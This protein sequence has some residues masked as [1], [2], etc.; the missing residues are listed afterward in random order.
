MFGTDRA[1]EGCPGSSGEWTVTEGLLEISLLQ[2]GQ[3]VT[4]R[5]ADWNATISFDEVTRQGSVAVTIN[6]TS[7]DLGATT[8]RAVAPD[9]LDTAAHPTARF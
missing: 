1:I 4:G 8:S 5:F 7:L 9:F 3:T 6:M 2:L